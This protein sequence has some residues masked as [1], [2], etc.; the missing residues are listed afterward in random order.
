MGI[1]DIS[2]PFSLPG[3]VYLTGAGPGSA[4]LLTLR[5]LEVLRSADIVLHDDLVS[6]DVLAVIPPHI[7]V[8]SAGKRC[9]LK[10]ISQEAINR[11]LIAEAR[12]G[13]TVVRLKGGDPLVFGRT[14]EEIF[15]L[16]EA[17]IGF[18]IIPGITAA[19]AAAAAAQIPLTE[20]IG[21]SK[22]VF[23][24]N[25]C[26]GHKTKDSF[27]E[28][29]VRDST[30]VFYMPG[31][32]LKSLSDRLMRSGLGQDMSCLLVSNVARNEQQLTR[33]TLGSLRT[34]KPPVAPS[35]LIVGTTVAAARTDEFVLDGKSV[36]GDS[37][38]YTEDLSLGDAT[39]GEEAFGSKLVL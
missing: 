17:G 33:S 13:H 18:E 37:L 14:H 7:V 28:S 3:K 15:A 16:R 30:L 31:Q 2:Q 19:T 22:L 23:L 39:I 21:A 34:L 27:D 26:F 8:Q 24:S 11:R 25:H 36:N 1:L 38:W 35:L 29:V 32:D 12:Q 20:R 9:G 10:K 5:A 6:E 4:G